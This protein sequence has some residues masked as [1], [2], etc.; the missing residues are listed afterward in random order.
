MNQ[1]DQRDTYVRK[2]MGIKNTKLSKQETKN[3][4]NILQDGNLKLS[5]QAIRGSNSTFLCDVTLENQTIQAI[6]KPTKGERPL[7]D[8]P[9]QTLAQ[10]EVAA[11]IVYEILGWDLV[12]PTV[13]R[14]KPSVFGKGSLQ[15]FIDHNPT[16]HYMNAEELDHFTMMRV[17]IFD[18][19]VNNA[20]RKSGHVIFDHH[21]KVWLIDHGLCFNEEKKLKT[22]IWNY[23]GQ[24]IPNEIKKD[25]QYFI[26]GLELKKFQLVRKLQMLIT[27]REFFTIIQR[28]KEVLSMDS[29]PYPEPNRRSYPWPPI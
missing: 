28:S 9:H 19:V 14:T 13:L 5:G 29:F 17:V 3:I 6:Y 10:R 24:T 15:F 8:F 4:I 27:E 21:Q 16:L 25:L 11:F 26:S 22:V 12:P 2:K 23:A 18:L 7:W 1:L 20:D